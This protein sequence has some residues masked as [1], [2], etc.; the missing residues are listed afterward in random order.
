LYTAPFA[1]YYNAGIQVRFKKGSSATVEW[2][3]RS[4]RDRLELPKFD[5]S[6]NLIKLG[7]NHH[8]RRFVFGL[9]AEYGKTQNHLVEQSF[10]MTRLTATLYFYP[11]RGHSLGGYLFFDENSHVLHDQKRRL[12]AG[13]NLRIRFTQKTHFNFN[14]QNN[15]ALEEYFRD[16]NILEMRLDHTFPW[17][18]RVQLRGRYTLLR[19]TENINEMAFQCKYSVPLAIPVARRKTVGQ[20]MGIVYDTE[21]GEKLKD[22]VLSV[23]GF[24]AVT[25]G[26]GAFIFPSLK[27]GKVYLTLDKANLEF[28][29]V[30]DV[31]MPVEYEIKGGEKIEVKIGVVRSAVLKGRVLVYEQSAP[32][33]MTVQ[34]RGPY[35]L[36]KNSSMADNADERI[37]SG[38]GL[39]NILI[40][41]V[42]KDETLRQLTDS[43][44][45][46]LFNELRP[47][48]W[49]VKAYGRLPEYHQFEKPVQVIGL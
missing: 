46:Y 43:E 3:Q 2:V 35:S 13:M 27:P 29:Q 42:N 11:V 26:N 45:T 8:I 39:E 16:R 49:Q 14:F 38:R 21:T 34:G 28:D 10:D 20:L 12:T 6:E 9:G 30:P 19:N 37:S 22:V 44:G 5:Y 7:F 23:N 17:K 15:Y 48:I 36:P 40:E 41:L 47:G 4:R 24:S 18:H 31:N 32:G 1:A 25:D 33:H